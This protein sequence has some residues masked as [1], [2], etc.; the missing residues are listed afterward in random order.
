MFS[1]KHW[2]QIGA[3]VLLTGMLLVSLVSCAMLPVPPV[4]PQHKTPTPGV[5]L[6]T[7]VAL[8]MPPGLV[9]TVTAVHCPVPTPTPAPTATP[10]PVPTPT[11]TVPPAIGPVPHG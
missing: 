7:I 4:P 8:T 9:P 6:P 11:P 3:G 5:F 10:T 1:K 2:S